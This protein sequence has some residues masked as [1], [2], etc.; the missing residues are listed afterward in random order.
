MKATVFIR[1]T[2]KIDSKKLWNTL[3][4][5]GNINVT[6]CIEYTLVYG[7][8]DITT[9]SHIIGLCASYGDIQAEVTHGE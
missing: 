2:G 5:F 8:S 9:A 3:E 1:I 6:D 7:D 4:K